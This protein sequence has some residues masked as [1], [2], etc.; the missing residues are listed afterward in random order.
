M[1]THARQTIREAVATI[2]SVTPSNWVSVLQTRIATSRQ[3]W[4]FIQVFVTDETSTQLLIHQTG[5]Y[6]RFLSISVVGMLKMPGTGGD[7]DKETIEDR[8]DA[9]CLEVETKMTRSALGAIVAN[10]KTLSLTSTMMEIALDEADQVS[11][12]VVTLVYEVSYNTV[13]GSPGTPV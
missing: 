1:T 2:L 13:E 4:P 5:L 12:G 11:H 7:S 9:L 6:D 10:A 3:I 8:M